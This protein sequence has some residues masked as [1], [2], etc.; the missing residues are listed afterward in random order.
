MKCNSSHT[1][2]TAPFAPSVPGGSGRT[3]LPL[4]VPLLMAFLQNT[5]LWAP[6]ASSNLSHK[7]AALGNSVLAGYIQMYFSHFID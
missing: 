6:E 1:S 7:L 4:K 5:R 3:N 2:V